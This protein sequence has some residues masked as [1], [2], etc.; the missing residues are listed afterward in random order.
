MHSVLVSCVSDDAVIASA[1]MKTE[2]RTD[3]PPFILPITRL[4]MQNGNMQSIEIKLTSEQMR[5][6]SA[7]ALG[8]TSGFC[9]KMPPVFAPR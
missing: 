5:F 3:V 2:E 9:S 6:I 1:V 8:V 4:I 7:R